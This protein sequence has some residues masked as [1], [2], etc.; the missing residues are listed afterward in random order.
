MKIRC[1]AAPKEFSAL[2][3]NDID[4]QPPNPDE[5][6]RDLVDRDYIDIPS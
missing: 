4:R 3:V 2:T 1:V 5:T 6:T